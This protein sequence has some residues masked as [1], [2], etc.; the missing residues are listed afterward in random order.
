MDPRDERRR[1]LREAARRSRARKRGEN[2]PKRKP[3]PPSL[4]PLMARGYLGPA[5]PQL[6]ERRA[7]ASRFARTRYARPLA[8]LFARADADVAE[9]GDVSG[10]VAS[11]V[12]QA[13][14]AALEGRELPD[15]VLAPPAVEPLLARARRALGE[16]AREYGAR[17]AELLAQAAAHEAGGKAIPSELE[18]AIG[19]AL[20]AIPKPYSFRY[21]HAHSGAFGG[22]WGPTKAFAY[23]GPDEYGRLRWRVDLLSAPLWGERDVYLL[24][25]EGRP[26]PPGERH[27]LFLAVG[28]PGPPAF[29]IAARA[30]YSG[31]TLEAPP[32]RRAELATLLRDAAQDE[33]IAP[34]PRARE[35]LGG[36][37]DIVDTH[38]SCRLLASG[39]LVSGAGEPEP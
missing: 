24:T 17:L 13:L 18:A 26:V 32:D 6:E 3:G 5:R 9:H 36:A 12:E 37:A 33:V 16:A 29:D 8:A 27:P 19:E 28:D 35:L 7:A 15:D 39:D 4:R 30:V 14:G 34:T 25:P 23:Q 31:A 1:T 11:L 2:V 22:W 38:G 20:A 21:L 10:E